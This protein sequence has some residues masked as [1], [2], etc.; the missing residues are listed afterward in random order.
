M[1]KTPS[2]FL[3]ALLPSPLPPHFFGKSKKLGFRN[4]GGWGVPKHDTG[5]RSSCFFLH[6]QNSALRCCWEGRGKNIG[7]FREINKSWL[8]RLFLSKKP[9]VT[10]SMQ[11]STLFYM[12]ANDKILSNYKKNW[13]NFELKSTEVLPHFYIIHFSIHIMFNI[14]FMLNILPWDIFCG[15]SSESKA[16]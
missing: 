1:G 14:F 4:E 11:K 15:F 9:T 6:P 12:C 7:F 16:T 10:F 2:N 8:S 5:V 13:T 3:H